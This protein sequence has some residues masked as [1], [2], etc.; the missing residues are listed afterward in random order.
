MLPWVWALAP[1]LSSK[2]LLLGGDTFSV[3]PPLLGPEFIIVYVKLDSALFN[4]A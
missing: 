1:P 2:L 3:V 4:P